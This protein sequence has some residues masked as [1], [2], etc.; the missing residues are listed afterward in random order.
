MTSCLL[1]V[2]LCHLKLTFATEEKSIITADYSYDD[3][4]DPYG[5]NNNKSSQPPSEDK[6]I[7][8]KGKRGKVKSGF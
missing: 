5:I 8:T 1:L 4:Y 3:D 2:S 7:N 6:S